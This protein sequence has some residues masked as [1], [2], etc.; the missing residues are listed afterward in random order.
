MRIIVSISAK[1]KVGR[2]LAQPVEYIPMVKR[3]IYARLKTK[4]RKNDTNIKYKNIEYR[5]KVP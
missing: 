1:V 2:I 5:S 3:F 4:N